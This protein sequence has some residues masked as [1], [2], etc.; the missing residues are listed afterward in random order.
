MPYT[1]GDDAT[2]GKAKS[3]FAVRVNPMPKNEHIK[4]PQINQVP[5]SKWY[6]YTLLCGHMVY[7]R[8]RIRV[9]FDYSYREHYIRCPVTKHTPLEWQAI[10]KMEAVSDEHVSNV[11]SGNAF[12]VPNRILRVDGHNPNTNAVVP[13]GNPFPYS[14]KDRDY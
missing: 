11:S 4:Q 12:I 8:V 9:G 14:S 10:A 13:S 5:E 7:S 6:C 1:L 2:N 3:Q